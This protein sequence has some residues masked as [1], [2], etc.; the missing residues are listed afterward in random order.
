MLS[1]LGL[2]LRRRSGG[3]KPIWGKPPL[4]I[5]ATYTTGDGQAGVSLLLASGGTPAPSRT[6]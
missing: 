1:A 6:L 2:L 3:K 4:T 5:K